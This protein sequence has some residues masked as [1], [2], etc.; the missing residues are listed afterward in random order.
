MAGTSEY[1]PPPAPFGA[2]AVGGL[3]SRNSGLATVF[4]G[5]ERWIGAESLAVGGPEAAEVEL[6]VGGKL[7]NLRVRVRANTLDAASI[8][9]V[10]VNGVAVGIS[11]AIPAGTSGS[12]SNTASS[13]VAVAGDRVSLRVSTAGS[14]LGALGPLLG[15][16]Q[17]A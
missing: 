4:F 14:T 11:V 5:A 2:S 10:W 3:I 8:V 15:S 1:I 16:V 13:F 7:K 6:A 17:E 9:E 12:F